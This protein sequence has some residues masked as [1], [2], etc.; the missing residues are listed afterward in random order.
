MKGGE[1]GMEQAELLVQLLAE[2]RQQN[3]MLQRTID[4]LREQSRQKDALVVRCSL[5]RR[6]LPDCK[7][8]STTEL[9][10]TA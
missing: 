9:K 6:L 2:I 8:S 10:F 7:Q 4:T 5:W 3:A 1:G